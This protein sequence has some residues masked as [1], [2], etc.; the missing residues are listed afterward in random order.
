MVCLAAIYAM[1]QGRKT[2]WAVSRDRLQV[3]V[4]VERVAVRA[5]VGA[6]WGTLA[7]FAVSATVKRRAQG[8]LLTAQ[9]F[10]AWHVVLVSGNGLRV[11]R[12]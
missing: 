6:F 7:D 1:H 2:A 8:V 5:A 9:P 4:L 10:L 12:H 3:P 11:V